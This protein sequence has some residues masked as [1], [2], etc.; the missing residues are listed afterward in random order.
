MKTRI[1]VLLMII[2]LGIAFAPV[3]GQV[4]EGSISLEVSFDPEPAFSQMACNENY[5]IDVTINNLNLDLDE[6]DVVST[7]PKAKFSGDIYVDISIIV[8]KEGVLKV[9]ADT[10]DFVRT[11]HDFKESKDVPLP[12]VGS[13]ESIEF[14]Y[15]HIMVYGSGFDEVSVD[16]WITFN[17]DIQVYLLNYLS[18]EPDKT[19]LSDS[20]G[21]AH[22]KYYVISDEKIDHV[23]DVFAAMKDELDEARDAIS[24]IGDELGR[25][26]DI[27]L[28]DYEAAYAAMNSHIEDGDYVLAI[29]A[30]EGYEPTWWDDVV[31]AMQGEV[32]ALEGLIEEYADQFEELAA[33]YEELQ[34]QIEDIA[35]K[36]AEIADLEA[37]I[38][39]LQSNSRLYIFGMVAL[40]VVLVAALVRM[41]GSKLLGKK[42]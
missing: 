8:S 23:N 30:Y 11:F 20:I 9:G 18:E 41:F 38:V 22:L 33:S 1:L 25:D 3:Q 32:E 6:G 2:S 4:P 31:T 42:A 16:E 35:E 34:S 37:Q 21:E 5:V 26:L 13:S 10:Q 14:P 7:L 19:D 15:R 28:G 39:T 27:D 17:L 24:D 12:T 40:G 29:A 36:D